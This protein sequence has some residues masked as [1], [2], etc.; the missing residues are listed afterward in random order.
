MRFPLCIICFPDEL[1]EAVSFSQWKCLNHVLQD[2][3]VPV[4]RDTWNAMMR[5]V[6][7]DPDV[8]ST[9]HTLHLYKVLHERYAYIGDRTSVVAEMAVNCHM[10]MIE[11]RFLAMPYSVGFQN[12][13][14]YKPMVND[15]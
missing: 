4:F 9:N 2:S 5:I 8:L 6:K 15:A 10:T 1:T 11:L 14:A 3:S 12:N 13:T 7:R